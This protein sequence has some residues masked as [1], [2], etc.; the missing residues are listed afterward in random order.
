MR[1][2][3]PEQKKINAIATSI[4]ADTTV[5]SPYLIGMFIRL[6]VV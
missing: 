2:L 4:T 5:I 3:G 1:R 6:F